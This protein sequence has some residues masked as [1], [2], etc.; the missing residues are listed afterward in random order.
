MVKAI[1][2]FLSGIVFGLGLVLSG[3]SNPAKVLNFLDIFGTFDPSLIF[4]MAGAI[5]IVFAGYK[6]ILKRKHP[7]FAQVFQIPTRKDLDKNLI[8]GAAFFGIGW[9]IGGFCPGPAISSLLLGSEGIIYF[10]P[11]MLVGLTLT[12]II[13]A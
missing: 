6:L 13:K 3:M 5:L 10:F 8:L 1:V 4:V 2:G 12:K 11:A 9:G 7:V